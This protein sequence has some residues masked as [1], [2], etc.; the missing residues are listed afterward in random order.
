MLL[1]LHP[2]LFTRQKL[3]LMLKKVTCKRNYESGPSARGK[4]ELNLDE[5]A[6]RLK[7]A[8][9]VVKKCIGLRMLGS[10]VV[11]RFSCNQQNL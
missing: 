2:S 3:T 4:E 8:D 1:P 10:K 6:R 7:V 5:L 9:N 11:L